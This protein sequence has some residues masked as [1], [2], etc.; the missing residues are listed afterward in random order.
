MSI[1][2]VNVYY[3]VSDYFYRKSKNEKINVIEAVETKPIEKIDTPK[4]HPYIKPKEKP[5][6]EVKIDTQPKIDSIKN[7][8]TIG[9]LK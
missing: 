7:T 1:V 3:G 2:M 8:D 4:P 6:N 5:I 9:E